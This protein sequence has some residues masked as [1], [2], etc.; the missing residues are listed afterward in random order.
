[1]ILAWLFMKLGDDGLFEIACGLVL[2]AFGFW[3]WA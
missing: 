3:Y 2:L 1:M